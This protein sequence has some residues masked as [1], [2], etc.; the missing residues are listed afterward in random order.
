[1]SANLDSVH[2]LY[3]AFSQGDLPAV[4]ELLQEDVEWN[5]P[6]SVPYGSQVGRQAVAENVLAKVVSDMPDFSV[7]PEQFIDGGGDTI[8]TVGT[9]RGTSRVTSRKLDT[10]FAHIFTFGLGKI[11]SFRTISDTHLWR[12]ALGIE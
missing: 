10:K 8:V 7:T 1:M 2:E 4:L 5:E 11:T 9:Y 3:A 12:Y 6:D